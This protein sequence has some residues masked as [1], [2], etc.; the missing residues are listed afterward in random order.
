MFN[1]LQVFDTRYLLAR[2]NHKHNTRKL[3]RL[4]RVIEEFKEFLIANPVRK[5]PRDYHGYSPRENQ[6]KTSMKGNK[7]GLHINNPRG[8]SHNTWL[9]NYLAT[10]EY[11]M[12]SVQST[13][14]IFP[15]RAEHCTPKDQVD[16]YFDMGW[17]AQ[18]KYNDTRCL[19]KYLPN[20]KVELWNRHGMRINYTPTQRLNDQ[21]NKIRQD[22]QLTDWSL[23]DGGLLDSKHPA[24]KDQ[25]VIW[26]I[27]VRNGTHLLGTSYQERFEQIQKIGSGSHYYQPYHGKHA[28][29][30]IG[31]SLTKDVFCPRWYTREIYNHLWELVTTANKPFPQSSP[32]FEGCVI[33]DPTGILEMGFKTK[34]NT[35]WMAKS[36]V[37]TGRHKF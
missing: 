13:Q 5:I 3:G 22:L 34:N 36:R 2:L 33:K 30:D 21:L 29:L 20:D 17:K 25:I 31:I 15:P 10:K 27:I 16:T 4:E 8:N 23:L 35:T 14:Y 28:A 6:I 11:K 7:S 19:I 1:D 12:L 18:I 32:V 9:T 37:T 24:I 26:D